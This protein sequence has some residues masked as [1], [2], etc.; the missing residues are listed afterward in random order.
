MSDNHDDTPQDLSRLRA[1]AEQADALAAEKA[2][3]ERQLMFAKAGIDTDSKLGSMLY[4]TFDG[5][6]LDALRAE[7]E[8]L[9]LLGSPSPTPDPAPTVDTS[10]YASQQEFRDTLAGGAPQGGDAPVSRDPYADALDH[11]HSDRK[12]GVNMETAQLAAIDRII[13]AGANRDGRVLFD[14]AAWRDERSQHGHRFG[15]PA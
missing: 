7:A 2:H 10:A 11:F 14:D 6:S 4:K 13:V 8:E 1:K 12:A 5:D 15:Q 9:G 3:L